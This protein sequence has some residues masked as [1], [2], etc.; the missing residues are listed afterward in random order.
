MIGCSDESDVGTK[1]R[2]I[3]P[4]FVKRSRGIF[5]QAQP[6]DDQFL[7]P[8]LAAPAPRKV[9]P[10]FS[11]WVLFAA[12]LSFDYAASA[13]DVQLLAKPVFAHEAA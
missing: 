9:A 13:D 12:P 5:F 7:L 11:I 6:E 10:F 3:R 2:G 8:A 4:R 1:N